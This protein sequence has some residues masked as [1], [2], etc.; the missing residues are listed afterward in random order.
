MTTTRTTASLPQTTWQSV[1]VGAKTSRLEQHPLPHLGRNDVLIRVRVCG[2]CASELHPW[3]HAATPKTF[4]HEVVGEVVAVGKDVTGFEP[5]MRV[6]GLI[7]QGFAEYTIAP[8]THLVHVP[9]GLPDEAALGE[10]LSCVISGMRRTGIELGDQVAVIGVGFMGLLSLQAA[11]LKG[12]S[13]VI[14][15]DSRPVALEQALTYG[16]NRTF[17]PEDIPPEMY[18]D[19]W[20]EMALGNGLN[21][22]IEAAGNPHALALAGRMVKAHGTL[23][24]VGFHQGE[25]IPINMGLW[26][27]KALNVINAHER[28]HAYQMDCM[29]R[30][31]RLVE[32]GKLQLAPLVTH[33][34]S[35][36]EVDA[37]FDTLMNKPADF[38]KAIIR[39]SD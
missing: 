23:A 10:P 37:A 33:S 4:G 12:P 21:I 5:S 17:K 15:V 39:V 27:W 11:V 36:Q 6:T 25:P 18:L 35:L 1:R 34:F 38:I 20:D 22:V 9:E 29:T 7:H 13:E 26:N 8:A 14:A 31:L 24:I 16:A 30:G 2:V 28:R 32:A 19:V 3:S